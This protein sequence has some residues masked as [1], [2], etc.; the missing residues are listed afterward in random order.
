MTSSSLA[1]GAVDLEAAVAACPSVL[2]LAGAGRR[3]VRIM[4]GVVEVHVVARWVAFLPDVADEVRAALQ[5]MVG[6]HP[7][8]VYIDDL[9]GRAAIEPAVCGARD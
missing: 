3:A 9:G 6:S 2:G 8:T 7:I 5:P 4:D 1:T